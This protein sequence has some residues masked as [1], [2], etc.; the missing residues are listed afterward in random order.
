MEQGKE[1]IKGLMEQ[2]GM[3]IRK[4]SIPGTGSVPGFLWKEYLPTTFQ[5]LREMFGIDNGDLL[6]SMTGDETLRVVPSPGK[7]GSIF[8]ISG[9]DR[10]MAKTVRKDEM[11]II[12][13]LM[14]QYYEHCVR[15]H[16]TLLVRFYGIY[17]VSPLLGR[18]V[19]VWGE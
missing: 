13:H 1:Y 5:K 6:L 18:R 3:E 14:A 4:Q 16:S 8:V 19:S 7:S 10:F 12:L 9:D 2:A 11:R 15:N 17:R